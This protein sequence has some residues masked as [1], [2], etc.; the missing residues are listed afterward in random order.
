MI[1]VRASVGLVLV[2]MG[3]LLGA[4]MYV[5]QLQSR[6]THQQAAAETR[7][8]AS[9][10]LA[11][12][13]RQSS[14]ELTM[15][16]RLY[17]STGEP[18]YREYFEQI[19]AIRAG[20]APRPENYEI[21][22]WDHVLARGTSSIRY[23]EPKSL[24][25]LMRDAKFTEQEF[26][27]LD[28]SREVSDRLARIETDVMEGLEALNIPP[29]DPRF[30]QQ[31]APLYQRLVGRDYYDYKNQIMVA[32]ERFI[33][34]V[35]RRTLADVQVLR[36][37]S[38]W[39]LSIQI[40]LVAAALLLALLALIAAERGLV[41]PLKRLMEVT[42][43]IAAGE[44]GQRARIRSLA[45]LEQLGD[46]FN[47][48]AG[49]IQ[50]DI[51]AREAAEK[52]ALDAKTAAEAANQAKSAFLAN[53]S[54]EIR[55]PLNAVIG[56]SELLRDTELDAEQRDSI[57]TINSS[58]EHL[59]SVINDILDFSKVESGMLELD[60]QVFDLRRTVEE[61][62]ELVANKAA[63]KRLDLACEFAPGT[64]EVVKGDRSRVRQ[65]LVNYLSNAIKFTER[66]DVLATISA[67]PA[68]DGLLEIRVGVRDTGIGI[69]QE[70]LDRLFKSFSQVDTSTT[71]RYGG[72]GLGLAICK[73]LAELMGGHV[74]VESHPGFGSIFS[75]S[76]LA[77]TDASWRVPPRPDTALLTGKRVLVVD[78]N[79]TNRRILR[80]AAQDWGM[81]VTDTASPE[82]ALL[83]IERG[84]VFDLLALDYLMPVMDGVELAASIRKR[85]PRNTL[86][87][88]LLSSVRRTA[89]SLPDFNLV[90]T[91]PVRRAALLDAFLEL[92]NENAS[93]DAHNVK[94]DPADETAASISPLRILLAEDNP[95]N[96]KVAVRMLKALG[97][98]ADVVDNGLDAVNTVE[99]SRYDLVLMD[100]HMPVM[101]GLE[102]TRRIRRLPPD[103]QP[104]VFAMTASVLDSERQDCIDAGM[105]RH[106]AKPIKKQQMED[107]LREVAEDVVRARSAAP[108]PPAT[109]AAASP[110]AADAGAGAG[111]D[112]MAELI[113]EMGLEGVTELIDAIVTTADTSRA[114]LRDYFARRDFRL[115]KRQVHTMK[116]NCAMVGAIDL[117]D[118]CQ[119]VE[120]NAAGED[121]ALIGPL[122]QQIDSGYEQLAKSLVLARARLE[123]G[124]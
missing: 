64:P 93:D 81:Q 77:E 25:A 114:N 123:V 113:D 75:F 3:V 103:R 29:G 104:R 101:D 96:Q 32:V 48:M 5:T 78:D 109:S 24:V 119:K 115:V 87:I 39:L 105:E 85:H 95:I 19:L 79:D 10:R 73:R 71:R 34:L 55:T 65:I 57:D 66:G 22:F 35:D 36:E 52:Q 117:S 2:V 13:M 76:F 86:P 91:K 70:R 69:P 50:N 74:G 92:L 59:L 110:V 80:A 53:M 11:E 46:R 107:M 112:K 116:S 27:S 6:N 51:A 1:S 8:N 43:R 26:K 111:A 84:D 67:T 23:G 14:N 54:H 56:M 99:R 49:A 40:A 82:E 45:E 94:A 16:V 62:L 44:Y 58:G 7:R 30:A 18:R 20:T 98:A 118:I 63:E 89:R 100:V 41:R 21:S 97:Y 37:R 102:A 17:V 83:W 31:V 28:D 72:T 106:M 124:S 90:M 9:Y 122:L 88:V 47:E 60:E 108:A 15:M 4:L 121:A 12:Q 38:E 42:Q 68:R 61:S 120:Q 33:G